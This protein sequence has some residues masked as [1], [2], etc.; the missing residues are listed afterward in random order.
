MFERMVRSTKRCLKKKI[1]RANLS[2]DELLTAVTEVESVVN[3]RPLSYI[4]PDDLEDPAHFLAGRR[5][6]NLPTPSKDTDVDNDVEVS[7]Q[8]FT[9]RWKHL[10]KVLNGFWQRWRDEYL[11]ELREHHRYRGSSLDS[12]QIAVGDVVVLH[13]D[14]KPRGFW[15]LAR[16]KELL[17]G[18]DLQVRGAVVVVP[19]KNGRTKTLNRP[20]QRLYPLEA[21]DPRLSE[22]NSEPPELTVSVRPKRKAAMSARDWIK[23]VNISEQDS[24]LDDD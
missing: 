13:D 2:Y 1:G 19:G 15:K 11:T 20:V 6:L 21:C 17:K 4:T 8:Y 12:C 16:V 22:D 3:S 24:E 23:A 7:P 10:N 14:S 5:L 18:R 9:R